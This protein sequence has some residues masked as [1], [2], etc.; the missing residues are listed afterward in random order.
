[1]DQV[2]ECIRLRHYSFRTEQQYLSWIRRFILFHGKRHPREMGSAEVEAFLS[3][4]A[5]DRNVAAATQ[6]QA[7]AALLFL[8]RHVLKQDLPWL[9]EV[10]RARKPRRLP[11]VLTRQETRALLA[12]LSGVYW[13][14]GNLLYGSGLR[15]MECLRLRV[16]DIDFDRS[17]VMVRN[18]KGG[19][20]R[21]TVLPGV[22]IEPLR[23]HLSMMHEQHQVAVLEGYGGVELP[24]SVVHKYPSAATDWGW[25]YVFP[26]QHASRDPRT[27]AWRRHHLMEDSV[28]RR[29]RSAVRRAA[30]EAGDLSY[31]AA[32]LRH[33]SAG[34]RVRYPHHPGVAGAFG[35]GDHADLHPRSG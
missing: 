30:G 2:R 28:Q 22:L 16:Q 25:Q 27:G 7:L 33:P 32:L 20:D 19:K 9:T 3:S 17:Q 31:T 10:V 15:L 35:S 6:N 23:G 8:Y 26:A 21:V 4:L 34:A 29:M 12:Q 1:M 13:L 14:V 24:V 18:G 5:T 11:L